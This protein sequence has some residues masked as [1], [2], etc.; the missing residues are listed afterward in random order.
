MPK[1][2]WV[3]RVNIKDPDIYRFYMEAAPSVLRKHTGRIL[4]RGDKAEQLEGQEYHRHVIV[5]FDS[6]EDAL[7]CYHSPEY[8]TARE[9]RNGIADVETVIVEG[10]D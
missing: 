3:A 8:Q 4:A 1:A 7:N 6:M 10:V 5:E 9:F 2:Y